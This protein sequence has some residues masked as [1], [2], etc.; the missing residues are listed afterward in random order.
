MSS[1]TSRSRPPVSSSPVNLVDPSCVARAG[2]AEQSERATFSLW[3]I[4][5]RCLVPG[6]HSTREDAL[7]TADKSRQDS[8]VPDCDYRVQGDIKLRSKEAMVEPS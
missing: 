1:A 4:F 3:A 2:Q 6:L 5:I 7:V 8:A